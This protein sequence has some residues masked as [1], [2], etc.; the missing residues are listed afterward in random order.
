[1]KIFG[2]KHQTITQP[3]SGHVVL[4]GDSIFDNENY[5]NKQPDVA[6]NLA[7]YLGE[8]WDVTLAARDGATTLSM[9]RQMAKI[10]QDATHLVVSVGG[11][12]A[13]GNSKILYDK[14]PQ[15]KLDTLEDLA[16]MQ[17]EFQWN[18]ED[19][20]ANL[21]LL[22]LPITLCTIYDC[23][24]EDNAA[25]ASRA[26]LA[27]FNDVILRY[28]TANQLP[29][30]DLRHVCTVPDDYELNIEPSGQGGAKIAAAIARHLQGVPADAG[31]LVYA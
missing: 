10:P 18:Y 30:V 19:A 24:F 27:L 16:Y 2:K 1:M 21:W 22:G 26:A 17:M 25:D 15:T 5:T 23:N 6:E 8:N 31:R 11:N 20:M 13:L 9:D 4:I 3:T 28:A 14:K 12:D 29:V 7:M